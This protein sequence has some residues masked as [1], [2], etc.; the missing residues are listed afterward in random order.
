MSSLTNPTFYC[1]T[2]AHVYR[3]VWHEQAKDIGKQGSRLLAFL[4]G[5]DSAVAET[6]KEEEK[7][8]HGNTA[9]RVR[10]LLCTP[11]P[12][13]VL[14]SKF[15]WKLRSVPAACEPAAIS[16]IASSALD[17]A[18]CVLAC[19]S[20]ILL[21]AMSEARSKCATPWLVR[22]KSFQAWATATLPQ[23]S[24]KNGINSE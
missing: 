16:Y 8:K 4:L 17:S 3:G 13:R 7:K 20:N 22:L 19:E 10:E 18:I 11:P 24:L 5:H 2:A 1:C 21:R 23:I 9:T 14:R 15:A 6:E 12:P